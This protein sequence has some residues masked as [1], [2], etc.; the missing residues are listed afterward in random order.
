MSYD[1]DLNIIRTNT[2]SKWY[3]TAPFILAIQTKQVFYMKDDKMKNDW[4]VVQKV[5][6]RH[7]SDVLEK[8]NQNIQDEEL[9]RASDDAY[10]EDNSSSIRLTFEDTCTEEDQFD[11][12]D[13]ESDELDPTVVEREN[14]V[15]THISDNSEED[16]LD[17]SSD[18]S[19]LI[20][21]HSDSDD[22]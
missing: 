13:I 5:Y 6:R 7:F 8:S 14:N 17:F 20:L 16:I 22:S 11:R 21:N 10:Q 3:K 12:Q 4:H 15:A 2:S 18:S 19:V 1:R 9:D